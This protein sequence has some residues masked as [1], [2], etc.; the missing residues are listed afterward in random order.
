MKRKFILRFKF[1]LSVLFLSPII[2]TS[3]NN[4]TDAASLEPT[5]KNEVI[6]E[7]ATAAT[8]ASTDENYVTLS[9]SLSTGG[10]YPE[11]YARLLAGENTTEDSSRS[12][13]P[14][15]STTDSS[16]TYSITAKCGDKTF[17]GTISS[18]KKSYTVAIPVQSEAMTCTVEASIK[19]G[20]A[21]LFTGESEAFTISRENQVVEVPAITL[22][23]LS[24]AG[25]GS[26]GL[27]IN[28]EGSGISYCTVKL[29][30][31]P[32]IDDDGEPIIDDD[33]S[34]KKFEPSS[35][36]I[37]VTKNDVTAKVYLG[38]FSFYDS[39]D[40][41][42]YR[43]IDGITVI[44][45]LTT[46]TWVKNGDEPWFSTTGTGSAKKTTCLVNADMVND[47][48]L[49]EIYVTASSN[50]PDSLKTGSALNPFTSIEEAMSKM[51]SAKDYTIVIQGTLTGSQTIPDRL[52]TSGGTYQAKSL[53]I[54]GETADAKLDGAFTEAG[55]DNTVLNI[56]TAVQVTI[57][58]LTITGGKCNGETSGGGITIA[59]GATVTLGDGT[60]AGFV[61]ITGNQSKNGGGI[62]FSGTSLSIEKNVK[63]SNN[64]A[65][66]NGGGLYFNGTTLRILDDVKISSNNSTANGGGIFFTGT[67]SP[68]LYF[69]G[70]EISNNN[71]ASGTGNGGGIYAEKGRVFICGNALIKNN[72]NEN[73]TGG[74]IYNNAG[75]VYFGYKSYSPLSEEEWTGSISGNNADKGGGIY[76]C[77]IINMHSGEISANSAVSGG[78]MYL[79]TTSTSTCSTIMNGSSK[80]LNNTATG[81]GKAL[82]LTAETGTRKNTFQIEG[83]VS[84]PAGTDGTHDLYLNYNNTDNIIFQING[85]LTAEPPVATFTL[86]NYQPN[87]QIL[88]GKTTTI[89]AS[90]YQKFA[91]TQLTGNAGTW[92]IDSEGKLNVIY[93][94]AA[95]NLASVITDLPAS[96]SVLKVVCT[97]GE[98]DFTE[99]NS[100]LK[101]TNATK[102]SLDI[103]NI[104]N[105]D[106]PIIPW[107]AFGG[108]N[109][110]YEV[111]LGVT[112]P[113][114]MGSVPFYECTNL[115]YVHVYNLTNFLYYTFDTYYNVV[116][117]PEGQTVTLKKYNTADQASGEWYL[118]PDD[119]NTYTV[120]EIDGETLAGTGHI[121][122]WVVER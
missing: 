27:E 14:V 18:D 92:T 9:G 52:K 68:T 104:S 91:L 49:K 83:A 84:I 20:T 118:S 86:D 32:I 75:T 114:E 46:N 63:I 50:A 25:N 97:G 70:G 33:G 119:P 82:Y 7:S 102:V 87:K 45:N 107:H 5:D 10:A 98:V 66:N 11:P 72:G 77:Y 93:N 117:C 53:T 81:N 38:E 121:I 24:S 101:N 120:R 4:L 26:I 19:K 22:K 42:I 111:Y 23:A 100:A 41:L 44:S 47:F 95:G 103:S 89:L 112:T 116:L 74:G 96:D 109:S 78:G 55:A 51:H 35:N 71:N 30:G 88:K 3:C 94:V 110:L 59:S 43:F 39:S 122:K 58:K 69:A 67:S 1:F 73:I 15:V 61:N 16:L 21:T 64:T 37:T 76:S 57:K 2:F 113:E 28:V 12:A 108:C 90:E 65:S 79:E 60:A 54:M 36:K 6:L 34:S 99:L 29:Y 13:F 17:P 106:S 48:A 80:I 62:Y 31:E 105:T 40:V 8:S 85:Q 115:K 56:K